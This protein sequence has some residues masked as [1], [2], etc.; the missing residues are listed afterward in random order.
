[1]HKST[2]I[3][4]LSHLAVQTGDDRGLQY[5]ILTLFVRQSREILAELRDDAALP[6]LRADLAHK[7]KGSAQTVG[8][9]ATAEA[10]DL[11]ETS[12]RTDRLASLTLDT[13]AAAVDAAC[14][15]IS[16]YLAAL[17]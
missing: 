1:V 10:A 7:L 6:R 13:L 11:A 12:L 15:N 9:F 3:L 4:D 8:A 5:E 2:Q 17:S 16:L 14:A